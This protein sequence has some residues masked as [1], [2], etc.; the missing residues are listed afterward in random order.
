[1]KKNYEDFLKIIEQEQKKEIPLP[2]T[3]NGSTLLKDLFKSSMDSQI[4]KIKHVKCV[5]SIQYSSFNPV[6]PYRKLVGDIFYLVVKTLE[7][8]EVGI[9][10]CSNGFF[11]NNNVEKNLFNPTPFNKGNPCYSYTL[12]GCIYQFSQ[13]FGKNMEMYINSILKTEP[14]FLTQPPMPVHRW[15]TQDEDLK[16]H[17]QLSKE[18]DAFSTLVPLY[19][20]DPK[21]IRDWNEEF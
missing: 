15:I 20:L 18:F 8:Q 9:T 6:P 12:V 14:Y 3:K 2:K 4:N 5:D 7:G 17:L 11:R 10:C 13:E 21:G 16:K 19:G 1:M